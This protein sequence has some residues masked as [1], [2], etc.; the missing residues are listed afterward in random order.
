M[1]DDSGNPRLPGKSVPVEA[2]IRMAPDE[3]LHFARTGRAAWLVRRLP[4]RAPDKAV[5][6]SQA[7]ALASQAGRGK[8]SK[9][10]SRD[11]SVEFSRKAHS[12]RL[13]SASASRGAAARR[14]AAYTAASGR[15]A[16]KP[17]AE[18]PTDLRDVVAGAIECAACHQKYPLSFALARP[19]ATTSAAHLT[20]TTTS[21][22]P[23]ST[24][25]ECS[26][27]FPPLAGR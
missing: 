22:S 8:S 20:N 25:P 9:P 3:S 14:A 13:S 4:R 12:S 7:A 6:Q 19:S 21:I 15:Q 1:P 10:A 11:R 17:V 26:T 24:R 18:G 5:H 16:G 27:V 23:K 2:L